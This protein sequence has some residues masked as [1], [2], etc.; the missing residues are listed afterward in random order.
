[1][2]GEPKGRHPGCGRELHR[3][4]SGYL[5]GTGA[6]GGLF[7]GLAVSSW[8]A[9]RFVSAFV[10]SRKVMPAGVMSLLSIAGTVLTVLALTS[11]R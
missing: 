3:V 8:L 4:V 6:R 10:R 5:I 2:D 11:L 9:V 7:L 1:M